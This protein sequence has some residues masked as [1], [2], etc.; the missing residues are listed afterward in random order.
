MKSHLLF[1]GWGV[2]AVSL[3]LTE[4]AKGAL[5]FTALLFLFTLMTVN[6]RKM[7]FLLFSFF[8]LFYIRTEMVE[9]MNV[10]VF[11]GE[12]NTL[13]GSIVDGPYRDG[14]RV[15][16][17][18]K[19]VQGEKVLVT[20][21][22]REEKEM[23]QL[24]DFSPHSSCV[25]HGELKRPLPSTMNFHDFDYVTFLKMN[26][27]HWIFEVASL[28]NMTCHL[29]S[30]FD[31]F[32]FVKA[33][34]H[35]GIERIDAIFKEPLKGLAAALIFGDRQ[36]L[37]VHIEEAYQRLGLIHILA[38]SGLHV[39]LVSGVSFIG[40]IRIGMTREKAETI[41]LWL[42]P[43]YMIV[44][45][46]AP[47]VIRA[48]TGFMLYIVLRKLKIPIRPFP[49]LCFL[50]LF[51]LFINPYYLLH[52]GFQ[53]SFIISGS[54]LLSRTIFREKTSFM[55]LFLV[56]VVSQITAIPIL[57]YH[58]YEFSLLSF[59]LNLLIVPLIAF[60]ILPTVFLLF[61]LSFIHP[62]FVFVFAQPFMTLMEYTHRLLDVAA[63]WHFFQLVLGKPS[64]I[65]LWLLSLS[66]YWWMYRFDRYHLWHV[67]MLLPTIGIAVVF[68]A[69]FIAPYVSPYGRVTVLDVGQ[70]DS[71]VIELPYR[72]GVYVID[73]GGV[74]PFPQEEWEE[75]KDPY[76]PGKRIV[77]P[78]LKARGI[79]TIDK[80][81]VTHGDIDHYGGLY[82][83]L[84][85]MRVKKILYGKGRQF[86][87][88]EKHFLQYV[89]QLNIPMEWVQRGM[90]W[91][92]GD[93]SFYVLG[94]EGTEEP[95]NNRSVVLYT[96]L[97][98]VKWLFTGDIEEEGEQFLLKNY[99]NLHAQF[100]KVGH[101]GSRTSTTEA[102]VQRMNPLVAFISAGR[103]NRFGHPHEETLQTLEAHGVN[104]YRTDEE[105]AIQIT[106]FS[107][108]LHRIQ[109]AI[110][111]NDYTKKPCS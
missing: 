91:K 31:L 67:Q 24:R 28:Q 82:H 72:K 54:L 87:E 3:V 62:S 81:I 101:H 96:E 90:G 85:E 45:G 35:A 106:F 64:V 42:L 66:I 23:S 15:Q 29:A 19:T 58:F 22:L 108:Q 100:L 95:G 98:G 8:L 4:G 74:I 56:T 36:F 6:Q 50:A 1:V 13:V 61:F 18:L 46:F 48:G 60:L 110:E 93:F 71:I 43:L 104:V 51:L 88:G 30:S 9:R 68:F 78:Y 37:S 20:T 11:H 80:V 107:N 57:L 12:E 89:A 2:A 40:L 73:G 59:V 25:L 109:T 102:F 47:S 83:L 34:R 55:Q 111:T 44:A 33:Y 7:Y 84:S 26:R 38:V 41:L 5:S 32:S 77:V 27:I 52:I 49:L 86:K 16:L 99:P 97:G 103:C 65:F 53:L 63:S 94:P 105:G 69:M 79:A 39:G 14:N 17:E 92:K 70:G 75:R 21:F 76:D 10:T